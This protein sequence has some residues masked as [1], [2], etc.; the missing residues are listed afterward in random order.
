MI[1]VKTYPIKV[2]VF[3]IY[4]FP[5][6]F[7]G[8]YKFNFFVST[9]LLIS[10]SLGTQISYLFLTKKKMKEEKIYLD[11]FN[12][13][14][15]TI[16]QV[17]M[18]SSIFTFGAHWLLGESSYRGYRIFF[19]FLENYL[20]ITLIFVLF[21][22]FHLLKKETL[23]IN[24]K[25]IALLTMTLLLLGTT[26][27]SKDRGRKKFGFTDSK[28][29][30]LKDFGFGANGV[31]LKKEYKG[32]E[33]HIS[34]LLKKDGGKI[35]LKK[36]HGYDYTSEDIDL[37]ILAFLEMIRI[38]H[39]FSSSGLD[40]IEKKMKEAIISKEAIIV[41]YGNFSL[42]YSCRYSFSRTEIENELCEIG[43][44]SVYPILR[45]ELKRNA[46]VG[47][48]SIELVRF[49][50]YGKPIEKNRDEVNCLVE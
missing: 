47:K 29:E 25:I 21:F 2:I 26:S 8:N 32:Y 43:D 37:F 30:K 39:S 10:V 7:F 5:I 33:V 42:S 11:I 23:L 19:I 3:L 1:H 20:S 13:F 49:F 46:L 36:K 4:L 34:P 6:Y 50:F 41:K 48:S 12:T 28:I 27:F 40:C 38:D 44:A 31:F 45:G 18:I 9:I 35:W 22:N 15:F 14:V 24:K 16:L 17:M